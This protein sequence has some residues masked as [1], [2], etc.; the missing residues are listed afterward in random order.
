MRIS[1]SVWAL[2]LLVLIAG[3]AARGHPTNPPPLVSC[4]ANPPKPKPAPAHPTLQ[5]VGQLEIRVELAREELQ[6]ALDQCRG[7]LETLRKAWPK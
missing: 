7:A 4:S 5:Q 6:V 3:C 1:A 2:S